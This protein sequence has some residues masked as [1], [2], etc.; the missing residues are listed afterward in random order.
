MGGAV[1]LPAKTA[2]G[3]DGDDTKLP[4]SGVP[5]SRLLLLLL[6]LL[7]VGESD[8]LPAFVHCAMR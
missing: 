5:Y 7:L 8:T 4:D 2:V 6:L 1:G 3:A